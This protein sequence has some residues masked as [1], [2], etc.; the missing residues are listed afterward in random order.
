V[1]VPR[2]SAWRAVEGGVE[3]RVKAR[4]GARREGLL[5]LAEGI[6]GPR[7]RVAVAAA[8]E[9]GR[10]NRALCAL[11]ADA[12]RLAPSRI[13]VTQ[14]L[15]SREKTVRIEGNAGDIAARLATLAKGPNEERPALHP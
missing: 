3:L 9:D 6:D 5:G 1:T 15:T 13:A 14:G 10:A 7:L 12:L 4:P 8:P 2:S 11:L